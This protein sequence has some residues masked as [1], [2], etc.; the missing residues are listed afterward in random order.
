MLNAE[1]SSG[2]FGNDIEE[3]SLT[4]SI[5]CFRWRARKGLVVRVRSTRVARS[6]I[7]RVRMIEFDAQEASFQ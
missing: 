6:E 3:L 4:I 5:E 1:A 7:R 2:E